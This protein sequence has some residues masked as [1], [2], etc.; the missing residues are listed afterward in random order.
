[1]DRDDGLSATP[2]PSPPSQPGMTGVVHRN[3][4]AMAQV[5]AE[6]DRRR[7]GQE[8]VADAITRFAGSMRFVYIHALLYGGWIAVNLGLLPAVKRFDPTF[9]ALA[10]VASVEALFLSTF[11]LISQNRAMAL[12]NRQAELDLQISLLTEHELTRLIELTDAIAARLGVETKPPD[13]EETKA[14]VQPEAVAG[15]NGACSSAGRTRRTGRCNL[16]KARG[17]GYNGRRPACPRPPPPS[18]P[19]RCDSSSTCRACSRSPPTS[20]PC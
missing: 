13:L 14:D 3:I 15:V 9:V 5:R 12:S 1:M 20:T 4:A 2:A 8:R 6:A 16:P 11:I 10:M 18:A 17:V 19:S 7:S